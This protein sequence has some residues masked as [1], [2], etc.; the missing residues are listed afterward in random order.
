MPCGAFVSMMQ[1]Q[2]LT[3][4][5]TTPAA[6]YTAGS[7]KLTS[8]TFS[9]SVD[10]AKPAGFVEQ[11]GPFLSDACSPTL[12]FRPDRPWLAP[13]AGWSDLAFRLLCREQG[14]AVCCTEMISAKGLVYNSKGTAELTA[15]VPDDTPLVAQLFGAEPDMLARATEILQGW[16]FVY[17]DLNMGCSVPKVAKTGAGS[18][19]LR[20]PAKALAAA[21]AVIRTAGPGRAGVKLRLG[22]GRDTPVW[23][24]LGPALADAGAAWLTLHPR[25]GTQ[26]FSGEADWSC[27]ARL[28]ALV[29]IPVVASGDLL[30]AEAAV[31]C[32]YESGVDAV[33]LARG[34][35]SDPTIFDGIR[36]LLAQ[37]QTALCP[38]SRTQLYALIRRHWD[39]SLYHHGERTT[40]LKMRTFVPRYIRHIPGAKALRSQLVHC[41]DLD[42]VARL[43]TDFLQIDKDEIEYAAT[44]PAETP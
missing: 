33:M 8:G 28:K 22:W 35:L 25:F 43:L 21:Q 36:R 29:N 41:A 42:E 31:R 4:A 37:P 3:A 17:F 30:S 7:R 11:G 27:L 14:A 12:S 24:T 16:G 23:D 40:L 1:S 13:L 38:K 34:A 15:T 39:L 32:L 10:S 6:V 20:D 9:L 2:L 44:A 18:A 19:L 26:A 5:G